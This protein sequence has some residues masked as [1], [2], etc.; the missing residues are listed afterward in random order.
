MKYFVRRFF[1]CVESAFFTSELIRVYC[2]CAHSS[3]RTN[4]FK[5]YASVHA[6][7]ATDPGV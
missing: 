3:W 5:M 1:L 7:Y 4:V 6:V 2:W